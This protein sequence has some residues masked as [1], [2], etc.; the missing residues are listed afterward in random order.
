MGMTFLLNREQPDPFA[1]KRGALKTFWKVESG[2]TGPVYRNLL[3]DKTS[4]DAPQFPQGGIL[5][6]EVP[7][8]ARPII[9]FLDGTRQ[10]VV[11]C[12]AHCLFA[13]VD[14]HVIVKETFYACNAHYLPALCYRDVGGA[15]EETHD[16]VGEARSVSWCRTGFGSAPPDERID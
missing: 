11:D 16:A 13:A 14:A 7:F 1:D 10:D 9:D 2:H 6:D 4:R 5:A 3:T 12:F 15:F 8:I